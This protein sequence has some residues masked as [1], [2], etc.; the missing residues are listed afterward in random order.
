MPH[1]CRPADHHEIGVHRPRH[2]DQ[3]AR[4][5][6]DFPDEGDGH[7]EVAGPLFG[8]VF[9]LPG[10]LLSGL[11]GCRP[12][13]WHADRDR[14]ARFYPGCD[15]HG[16]ESAVG[17]FGLTGR[18]GERVPAGRRTIQSDYDHRRRGTN[19]RIR[20]IRPGQRRSGVGHTITSGFN[21][22]D[23]QGRSAAP[24]PSASRQSLVRSQTVAGCL[25]CPPQVSPAG[26]GR[27]GRC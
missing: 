18:P 10:V 22:C 20:G 19:G 23:G 25:G 24:G 13:E 5:V 4:L 17:T 16:E 3:G 7:A 26:A 8:V 21:E 15:V 1:L 2:A 11:R 12:V 14:G 9:Q 27:A 6:A